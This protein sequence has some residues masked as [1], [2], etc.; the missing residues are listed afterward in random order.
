MQPWPK[1]PGGSSSVGTDGSG[2]ASRFRL[3]FLDRR[4][5]VRTEGRQT[6]PL[7]VNSHAV[8][9]RGEVLRVVNAA[10]NGRRRREDPVVLAR[11]AVRPFR[12]RSRFHQANSWTRRREEKVTEAAGGKDKEKKSL[13][14]QFY[15][16]VRTETR[17]THLCSLPWVR[18]LTRQLH[19]G[20][21]R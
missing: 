16:H 17:T 18:Y 4:A 11:R 10:E 7:V 5:G 13:P 12:G 6:R 3:C 8:V 1:L 20:V 19:L 2:S 21:R 9:V 14:K 15:T